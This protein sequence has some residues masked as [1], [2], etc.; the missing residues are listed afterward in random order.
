MRVSEKM[1]AYLS[2]YQKGELIL[3]NHW[4]VFGMK[5]DVL[6]SVEIVLGK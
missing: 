2:K 5:E 4:G 1:D 3:K 6:I